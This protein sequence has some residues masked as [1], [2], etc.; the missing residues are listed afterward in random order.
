MI[1]EETYKRIY[2]WKKNPA[3]YRPV[4]NSYEYELT[5]QATEKRERVTL[6]IKT[7]STNISLS[8]MQLLMKV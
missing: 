1:T 5:D 4:D 7:L 3:W 8:L 2:Y 6:N